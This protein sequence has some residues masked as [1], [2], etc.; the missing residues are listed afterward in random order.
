MHIASEMEV[1]ALHRNDLRIA[2]AGGAALDAEGGAHRRL[3]QG[4]HPLLADV[5]ETLGQPDGGRGLALAERS[6]GDGGHQDVFGARAIGQLLDGGQIDLG[7]VASVLLEQM[8]A[9]PDRGGD[10]PDWLQ[11]GAAGDFEVGGD[12]HQRSFLAT[13]LR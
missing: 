11:G 8:G 12:G 9:D 5:L 6:G 13:R 1:E 10:V 3:A 4:Q 2:P 7:D